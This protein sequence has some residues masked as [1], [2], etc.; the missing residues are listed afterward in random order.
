MTQAIARLEVALNIPRRHQDLLLLAKFIYERMLNNA[1]FPN[2][3]PTLATLLALITAFDAALTA[4]GPGAGTV[5]AE[6]RA[7]LV[8]ALKHLR[9]Y[10]QSV[11]EVTLTGAAS[12]V[13]SSGMSIRKVPVRTKPP[14]SVKRGK[15]SGLAVLIATA[16]AGQGTYYWEMSVDSKVWTKLPDT[17]K[18]TT[19]V[20]GLTPGQTYYFRFHTLSRAGESDYSQIISFIAT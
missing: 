4:K 15:V 13:E 18:S 1:Q 8:A 19:T 2:P 11:A 10:V 3:T 9:D 20:S 6:A 14:F 12:L 7:A 16:V 17:L 5:R